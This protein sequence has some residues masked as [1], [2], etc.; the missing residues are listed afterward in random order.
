MPEIVTFLHYRRAGY[1]V[2][3]RITV[4][5]RWIIVHL[6]QKSVVQI[7]TFSQ[8]VLGLHTG[9]SA[10]MRRYQLILVDASFVSLWHLARWFFNPCIVWNFGLS[11]PSEYSLSQSLHFASTLSKNSQIRLDVALAIIQFYRMI[12]LRT[13]L[14]TGLQ[15]HSVTQLRLSCCKRLWPRVQ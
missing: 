13:V 5:Q 8:Q 1:C 15:S 12:E 14:Q 11:L 4:L 10:R 9:C 7:G 6:Q 2:D 3:Q